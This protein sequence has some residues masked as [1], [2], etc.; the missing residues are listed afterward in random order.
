[1]AQYDHHRIDLILK[2]ETA[3]PLDLYR[4]ITRVLDE[5]IGRDAIIRIEC[6][7]EGRVFTP[8]FQDPG[9]A[10][11]TGLGQ[12]MR[13]LAPALIACHP[14]QDFKQNDLSGQMLLDCTGIVFM[15]V[16][17]IENRMTHHY[18]IDTEDLSHMRFQPREP[19]LDTFLAIPVNSGTQ[20]EL[21]VIR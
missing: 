12:A 8:V 18:Y 2:P 17:D 11:P 10:L 6:S 20:S 14:V 5:I 15:D 19:S 3:S 1:M 9:H 21:P 13:K 4:R 7:P 16:E